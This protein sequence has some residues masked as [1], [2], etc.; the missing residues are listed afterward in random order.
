MQLYYLGSE[1]SKHY[2]YRRP[3]LLYLWITPADFVSVVML[4][5]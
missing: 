1:A 2:P 5:I 4:G 3:L